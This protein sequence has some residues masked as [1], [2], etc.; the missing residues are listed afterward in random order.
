MSLFKPEKKLSILAAL[1][2]SAPFFS[3]P[4]VWKKIFV[5]I[6]PYWGLFQVLSQGVL[7]L[8]ALAVLFLLPRRSAAL[9]QCSRTRGLYL[10]AAAGMVVAVL[11]YF[12]FRTP[13]WHIFAAGF[14]FLLVPAGA[15][16]SRQIKKW[17]VIYAFIWVIPFVIV[18]F[19]SFRFTGWL[20]NWN[21]N[22][23]MLFFVA[24]LLVY[25]IPKLHFYRKI[26]LVLAFAMLALGGMHIF[27]SELF[28]RGLLLGTAAATAGVILL[29]LLPREKRSAAVTLLMFA[30][31][32]GFVL[33]LQLFP[34]ANDSRIQLW[35][36]SL[37]LALSLPGG[38]L[39]ISPER[40]VGMIVP[41]LP[42][43]YFLTPYA[44]GLH[45][46]PHN[47]VLYYFIGYGFVGLVYWFFLLCAFVS[48]ICRRDRLGLFISWGVLLLAFYGQL[49]VLLSNPVAGSWF[50][51]G[52]GAVA[53][54]GLPQVKEKNIPLE[55][56]WVTAGLLVLLLAAGFAVKSS[57]ASYHAF[58]GNQGLFRKDAEKGMRHLQKSIAV[59]PAADTLYVAARSALFDFRSP[60]AALALLEKLRKEFVF[61]SYFHSYSLAGRAYAVKGELNSSLQ[62]FKRE[63]ALYPVSALAWGLR[64]SV[65]KEMKLPAAEIAE[66]EAR[67][68]RNMEY[69]KLDL[70]EFPLLRRHPILDDCSPSMVRTRIKRQAWQ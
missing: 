12:L 38:G 8:I 16:L 48:G 37:E 3:Y 21:W 70:S 28:P 25:A 11:Q 17:M 51:L 65:E 49:D 50:L 9:V 20:G 59:M 26:Q 46:H 64:L 42:E 66:T 33:L 27:L 7:G 44:A 10:C 34:E 55:K 62:C 32:A 58:C 2:L 54:T 53:G 52:A 41:F 43:G 63:T 4:L 23:T 6:I 39:G 13:V 56:C 47:E 31:I 5:G 35:K 14:Y 30:G 29:L 68:K 24:A 22:F 40:F 45:P 61:D 1:L 19:T 60:D 57:A 18:F 15:V 69:R 67:F 36:G